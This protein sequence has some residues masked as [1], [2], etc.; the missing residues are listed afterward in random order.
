MAPA[1]TRCWPST[2]WRRRLARLPDA[3][4]PAAEPRAGGHRWLPDIQPPPL[5]RPPGVGGHPRA[6]LID[7]Q[8]RPQGH[9]RGIDRDR[10]PRA[11]PARGR[12]P[13]A[14][15]TAHLED[16]KRNPMGAG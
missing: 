11:G 9:H 5:D 12:H 8:P 2:P 16:A 3:E 4:L 1:W 6:D 13:L 10:L 7:H 15:M 14:R